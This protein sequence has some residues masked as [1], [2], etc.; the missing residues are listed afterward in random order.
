ML[1]RIKDEPALVAGAV[2]AIIA[3]A[4]AFGLDLSGDQIAA[5]LGVTAAI[6]AFVVRR[7]VVPQRQV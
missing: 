5:I 3:L 7:K 2:Q 1:D 4:V 6:L